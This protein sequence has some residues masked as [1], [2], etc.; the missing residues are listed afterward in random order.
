MR[1]RTAI[2]S[3][4]VS[5]ALGLSTARSQLPPAGA[6]PPRDL[7][8]PS[9][10][11][12]SNPTG[13]P[14]ADLRRAQTSAA[15]ANAV[16]ALRESVLALDV[17]RGMRVRD[18]INQADA[19]DGLAGAMAAA[20]PLGGPRWIDDQTCQV[21]VV[22]PGAAVADAVAAMAARNAA[23]RAVRKEILDGWRRTAFSATGSSAAGGVAL[24][25]ARPR[26]S[27]GRWA[28]VSDDDR[29]RAVAAAQADAVHQAS[30]DLCRAADPLPGRL[31]MVDALQRPA[32]VTRVRAY[33]NAQPVTHIEFLDDLTVSLSM[34]VDGAGLGRTAQQAVADDQPQ[35]SAAVAAAGGWKRFRAAV[36]E[37]IP[38]L[39][40]G[41][42]AATPPTLAHSH[43]AP[44]SFVLRAQPPEWVDRTLT[45][46]GSAAASHG[47]PLGRLKVRGQAYAAAVAEL[48]GK[49][50]A[51]PV[52]PAVTLGDAARADAQ[53]AAAVS[54]L[55]L[56]AHENKVTFNADGSVA[57]GVDLN[58][59]DAW[60][61]LRSSP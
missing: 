43:P 44:P 26:Q 17:G 55:L 41:T 10:L 24:Q 40:T 6:L 37:A 34:T 13:D 58:L 54:R 35:V 39:I 15:Q 51:L 52:G 1:V 28:E 32:V 8:T 56:D 12:S 4:A 33:L 49:L 14:V 48:R 30:D 23:G 36:V 18:L 5:A 46:N 25:Q 45:A 3:C 42:A 53:V 2:L 47:A 19:T 11:E 27:G 59:R 20:R 60:D 29:R 61:Q 22:V 57:V 9:E 7:S 31:R 50:L 21:Q 16:T 38:S